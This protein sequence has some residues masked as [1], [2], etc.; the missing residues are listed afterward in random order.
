MDFYVYFI[1]TDCFIICYS[2]DN[3]ESYENVENKWK[4]EILRFGDGPEVP[5]ILA[6]STKTHFLFSYIIET[7]LSS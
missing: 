3:R 5:V 7:W 4:P 1:Q 2:V 6:G